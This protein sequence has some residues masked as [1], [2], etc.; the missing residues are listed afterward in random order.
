MLRNSYLQMWINWCMTLQLM[1]CF[2]LSASTFSFAKGLNCGW[3]IYRVNL[4][5]LWKD[6]TLI[7][8]S[9]YLYL[10]HWLLML[11]SCNT[12]HQVILVC[13][14][15]IGKKFPNATIFMVFVLKLNRCM[16]YH[17]LK[18]LNNGFNSW[19][20]RRK[21]TIEKSDVSATSWRHC[22]GKL[23]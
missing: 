11:Y 6:V 5:L 7:M 16:Y 1:Q 10:S 8:W 14:C 20:Y 21:L 22:Q 3:D 19:S 12:G 18:R 9:A 4:A 23:H 2:K 15:M 13:W 17:I